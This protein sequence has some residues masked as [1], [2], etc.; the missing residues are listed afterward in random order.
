MT[1]SGQ[2]WNEVKGLGPLAS[3]DKEA[4][5]AAEYAAALFDNHQ[6]DDI[7]SVLEQWTAAI[8]DNERCFHPLTRVKVW[9][10][11]ARGLV[12][13]SRGRWKE[14][15]HTSLRLNRALNDPDNMN[16]TL[17]YLVHGLLRHGDASGAEAELAVAG[18][19][20]DPLPPPNPWFGFMVAN[21]ARCA[22]DRWDHPELDKELERAAPETDGPRHAFGLYF[23]ATARQKHRDRADVDK[24]FRRAAQFMRDEAGTADGNICTLFAFVLDLAAAATTNDSTEWTAAGLAIRRFLDSPPAAPLR[25]PLPR[26]VR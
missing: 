13:L 22:G 26:G 10:T 5:A 4:D 12:I 1:L 25:R 14:L 19:H 21:A 3:D 15:F 9:N 7:P 6:F 17:S 16:R 8:A 23:Q 11:L 2:I 18:L 24:R 20:R